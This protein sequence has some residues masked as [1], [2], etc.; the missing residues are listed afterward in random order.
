M[1][2]G[3]VERGGVDEVDQHARRRG[4]SAALLGEQCYHR[5]RHIGLDECRDECREQH[6]AVWEG[7]VDEVPQ[8]VEVSGPGW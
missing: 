2:P 5:V 8:P 3:A 6:G 7:D 4:L 1:V